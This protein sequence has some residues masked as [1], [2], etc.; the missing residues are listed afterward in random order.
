MNAAITTATV[1]TTTDTAVSEAVSCQSLFPSRW[2]EAS[3]AEDIM[4]DMEADLA[5]MEEDLEV[6]LGVLRIKRLWQWQPC[7]WWRTSFQRIR[8]MTTSMEDIMA[9]IVP[10]LAEG[11]RAP[12]WEDMGIS[13]V[14]EDTEVNPDTVTV[15]EVMVREVTDRVDTVREVT[16]K[17]DTVKEV[18]DSLD[19]VKA[20]DKQDTA[21]T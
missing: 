13:E 7:P 17:L 11:F 2:A 20:R 19:T 18:M 10:A 16:G 6:V 21:T 5:V 3:L 9:D 4:V 1:T 15:K 12:V 14:M 8:A